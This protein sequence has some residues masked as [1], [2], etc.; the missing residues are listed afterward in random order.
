[1]AIV[2][3][4]RVD[5][6][7]T[8]PSPESSW[9]SSSSSESWEIPPKRPKPATQAEIVEAMALTIPTMFDVSLIINSV[10]GVFYNNITIV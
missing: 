5:A 10:F 1:M 8:I 2:R 4:S 3:S 7:A 6:A 9:S